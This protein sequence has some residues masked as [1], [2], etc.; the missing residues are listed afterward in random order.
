MALLSGMTDYTVLLPKV[1]GFDRSLTVLEMF[2]ITFLIPKYLKR[3]ALFCFVLFCFLFE[4]K[5]LSTVGK[6]TFS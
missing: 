6:F 4:I 3:L 2:L 1:T 5:S